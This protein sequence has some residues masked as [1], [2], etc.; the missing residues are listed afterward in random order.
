M[1]QNDTYVRFKGEKVEKYG[2]KN[3]GRIFGLRDRKIVKISA[4]KTL[5][6]VKF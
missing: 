3:L 2:K 5:L 6:I 4:G 1:I